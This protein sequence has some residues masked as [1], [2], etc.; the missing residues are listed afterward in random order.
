MEN[1]GRNY[2]FCCGNNLKECASLSSHTPST[3]GTTSQTLCD[4]CLIL[5][6]EE[7]GIS[8]CSECDERLCVYC[9]NQHKTRKLTKNHV[10]TSIVCTSIMVECGICDKETD[11]NSS[12]YCAYCEETLCKRCE[13]KHKEKNIF[14]NHKLVLLERKALICDPCKQ[15]DEMKNAETFC[16]ICKEN[17]CDICTRYHRAQ[18]ATKDH[19]LKSN[20]QKVSL[21]AIV[22]HCDPCNEDGAATKA[23]GVCVQCE[24]HLCD[25]CA[26]QHKLM[27][28]MKDHQINVI[29]DVWCGQCQE[30]NIFENAVK[31]CPECNE[32][33]CSDCCKTHRRFK[34]TK[35]HKL[36]DVQNTKQVKTSACGVCKIESKNTK[37][38]EQCGLTFCHVCI[39]EHSPLKG[40]CTKE[41]HTEQ[42]NGIQRLGGSFIENLKTR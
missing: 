31:Y 3:G 40:T 28:V 36:V 37:F 1:I 4:P 21:N 24:E 16:S 42:M 38:C 15:N 5:E 25:E 7:V 18:K 22:T 30:D 39:E 9:T 32:H 14:K 26:R 20:F 17:L 2:D 27:K 33:L 19:E 12:I 34:L 41:L 23:T 29:N 13:Q 10:L 8:L 35:Y 11:R 6:K